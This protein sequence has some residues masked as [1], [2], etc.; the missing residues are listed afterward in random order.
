MHIKETE[1]SEEGRSTLGICG[2]RNRKITEASKSSASK[3]PG[4]KKEST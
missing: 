1:A 4:W 3:N 2:M